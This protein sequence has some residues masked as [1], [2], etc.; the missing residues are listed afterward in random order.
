VNSGNTLTSALAMHG[1]RDTDTVICARHGHNLPTESGIFMGLVR[2]AAITSP[3]Y[4]W[5]AFLSSTNTDLPVYRAAVA[6]EIAELEDFGLVQMEDW[7]ARAVARPAEQCEDKLRSCELYVAIIGHR[8]GS[9]VAPGDLPDGLTDLGPLS[10]TALE[11]ELAVRMGLPRLVY[12]LA[13]DAS[14]MSG[15]AEGPVEMA[16][17]ERLRI[18]A[19]AD[20][21][22][23]GGITTPAELGRWVREDL[24]EWAAQDSVDR[25]LVD[26]F[27]IYRQIRRQ[28][29][30]GKVTVLCG[31]PGIGKSEIIKSLIGR[32]PLLNKRFGSR[33]FTLDAPV[34]EPESWPDDLLAK[35][36]EWLVSQASPP[37]SQPDIEAALADPRNAVRAL[38][39]TAPT[40]F[41]VSNVAMRMDPGTGNRRQAFGHLADGL[42]ALAGAG[43]LLAETN[44][45]EFA[46]AVHARIATPYNPIVGVGDLPMEEAIR[47]IERIAPLAADCPNET[48]ELAR[49]LGGH[50]LTLV[51][52]AASAN[53]ATQYE[54]RE[55][56]RTLTAS[57]HRPALE[58]FRVVLGQ[59]L[60]QLPPDAREL[61]RDL[62]VLPPK[63]HR[64]DFAAV[65][66]LAVDHPVLALELAGQLSGRHID[67]FLDEWEDEAD[68]AEDAAHRV[69]AA[70]QVRALPALLGRLCA[71]YLLEENRPKKAGGVPTWMI[72]ERVADHLLADL[73][74]QPGTDE[75]VQAGR[76]ERLEALLRSRVRGGTETG[77][78]AWYRMEDLTWQDDVL[79][80]LY[81][82][83]KVSPELA[84]LALTG[85]YLD[86]L[87]WWGMIV[88]F[89]LIQRLLAI[90]RRERLVVD[91][92]RGKTR[93][94]DLIEKTERDYPK[95]Y[96]CASAEYLPRWRRT[97]RHLRGLIAELA[98]DPLAGPADP[99][100]VAREARHVRMVLES[101]LAPSLHY[102]AVNA[103]DAAERRRLKDEALASFQ[104]AITLARQE[105]DWE[106]AGWT[107]ADYGDA[108]VSFGDLD[109]AEQVFA[110]AEHR[111]EMF[112]DDPKQLDLSLFGEIAGTRARLALAR[113]QL[114]TAFE[115]HGRAVHYWYA[116]LIHPWY[117]P[118]GVQAPDPANCFIYRAVRDRCLADLEEVAR[119]EGR[120]AAARMAALVESRFLASDPGRPAPDRPWFPPSPDDPHGPDEP[121]APWGEAFRAF[122]LPFVRYSEQHGDVIPVP[123]IST[124]DTNHQPR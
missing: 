63:P 42:K 2:S 116:M 57:L 105:G 90:A 15:A 94:L 107:E 95:G 124:A 75:H 99:S 83:P 62:A 44:N 4:R 14:E 102:Q 87:W 66:I 17:I 45:R 110:D 28:T 76:Y 32:D 52:A 120:A 98:P 65:V 1:P 6:A 19:L 40:L 117:Y 72:T 56:L 79:T 121:A 96:R 67:D 122:A 48:R 74:S 93:F 5:R 12:L 113:G 81:V 82:L 73:A 103:T 33:V 55:E 88:D 50:P 85:V 119:T 35:T 91:A 115:E 106:F 111:A 112:A 60:D 24:R 118:P 77:V 51:L 43:T 114:T 108:L 84:R 10:Y 123:A 53:A 41:V 26:R 16:G 92:W 58:P 47:L 31:P 11:Y 70:A 27:S 100:P 59:V 38:A 69:E 89:P 71:A 29:L 20:S 97:E 37:M 21:V 109:E 54:T 49:R 34:S 18:R 104:R 68:D 25:G 64:F 78:A 30:E 46:A 101:F 22:V 7:G 39:G 61:L 9:L 3:G 80:W 86:A 36:V 23:R 8:Y 13:P